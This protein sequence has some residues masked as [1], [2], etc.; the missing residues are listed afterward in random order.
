M[1]N[2]TQSKPCGRGCGQTIDPSRAVY[3]SGG[4]LVCS[5]CFANEQQKDADGRSQ[6]S[7]L[8][9]ALGAATMGFISFFLNAIV[10]LS[11]N[12]FGLGPVFFVFAVLAIAGGVSSFRT[13]LRPEMFRAPYRALALIASLIAIGLGLGRVG[14]SLLS[15]LFIA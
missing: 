10:T 3:G 2:L 6:K 1:Q 8:K 13:Y 9:A 7:A 5:F 11:I 15:L 4:V 14:L 12:G